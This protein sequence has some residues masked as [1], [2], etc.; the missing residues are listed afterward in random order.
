[1]QIWK[2]FQR[3]LALLLVACAFLTVLPQPVCAEELPEEEAQPAQT[4][5]AVSVI[6]YGPYNGS[7]AIG[8]MQDGTRLTVLGESGAFYKVDCFD[9]KGYIAKS[10]VRR[11]GDGQYY[12]N[13][14]GDSS[15]TR[16]MRSYSSEEVLRLRSSLCAI[17]LKY[18]GRP[19]VHGGTGPWGFDCCGLTQFIYA[20]EGI[21]LHRNQNDQMYDGVIVAKEDLQP[22]DLIFFQGTAGYGSISS[23][24]GMYI[25]NG[26][27]IHA[28]SHGVMVVN[29]SDSYFTYHYLCSRRVVLS[30]LSQST[31][32]TPLGLGQNLN[33]SYWRESSRG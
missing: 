5:I 25:G 15:E 33:S 11:N 30:D 14:Q 10:Q 7:A 23:H 26:K 9:M 2:H 28:G 13:C 1:M 8:C 4:G 21:A 16:T 32:Q 18:Q 24:V 22:G 31:D 29:L 19:Y 27:L 6:H 3:A 12:V 17:S 20:Q